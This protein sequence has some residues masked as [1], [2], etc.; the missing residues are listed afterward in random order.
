MITDNSIGLNPSIPKI[1]EPIR[2]C[3]FFIINTLPCCYRGIKNIEKISLA[4]NVPNINAKIINKIFLNLIQLNL[5]I[6]FS[7][8]VI[9]KIFLR[10]NAYFFDRW[11]NIIIHVEKY[12]LVEKT[13]LNRAVFGR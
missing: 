9:D 5:F 13:A 12:T 6:P 4:S 2:S 11:S 1:I 10:C 3:D 8:I 7:S